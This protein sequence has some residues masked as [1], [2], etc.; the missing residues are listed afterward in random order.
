MNGSV[1]PGGPLPASSCP[2]ALLL[3]AGAPVRT[4]VDAHR[5][6]AARGQEWMDDA[7]SAPPTVTLLA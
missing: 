3:P 4:G 2:G 1:L 7:R 6:G 5:G